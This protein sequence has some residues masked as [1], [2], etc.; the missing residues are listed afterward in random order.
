M[1]GIFISS[2][3]GKNKEFNM[4]FISLVEVSSTNF[5]SVMCTFAKVL[6]EKIRFCCVDGTNSIS[7]EHNGGQRQTR[8]HVHH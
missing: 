1:L 3:D 4:D 2:F 5:E 7:G 6:I 8:N